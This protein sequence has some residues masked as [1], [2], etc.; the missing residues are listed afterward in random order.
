MLLNS[1]GCPQFVDEVSKAV[2]CPVVSNSSFSVTDYLGLISP[3]RS[4]SYYTKFLLDTYNKQKKYNT[5]TNSIINQDTADEERIGSKICLLPNFYCE[6][7]ISPFVCNRTQERQ[8][9][10]D[11]YHSTNG[12]Y[13]NNSIRTNWLK[14]GTDYCDWNG[15]YCCDIYATFHKNSNNSD[16]INDYSNDIDIDIEFKKLNNTCMNRLLFPSHNNIT[17]VLPN[18]WFNSTVFS[19]IHIQGFYAGDKSPKNF[20][21]GTIPNFKYNLPNLSLLRITK[22]FFNHTDYLP[23]FGY[24]NCTISYD[25]HDSFDTK[26]SLKIPDWNDQK[27]M[28]YVSLSDISLEGTIPK[29]NKWVW[30]SNLEITSSTI[31]TFSSAPCSLSGG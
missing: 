17:G 1:N 26:Y 15:V 19:Y 11:F 9:L 25:L 30:P 29:W 10:T 28:T 8:W 3:Y 2:H 27:Y 18:Y 14:N 12:E 4:H 23:S 5:N 31:D 7:C 13:W 6:T 22:E 24:G 21:H 16:H 20:L